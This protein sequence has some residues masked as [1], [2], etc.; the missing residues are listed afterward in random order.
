MN[1]IFELNN[2]KYAKLI[3]KC[4][5]LYAKNNDIS[6]TSAINDLKTDFKYI[7]QPMPIPIYIDSKNELN[8]KTKQIINTNDT[9][10]IEYENKIKKLND[11]IFGLNQIIDKLNEKFIETI[12][13]VPSER[14]IRR[15]E[16]VL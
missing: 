9:S 11:E 12:S 2:D 5:K 10:N 3:K 14:D 8:N 4:K 7:V 13:K 16:E 15:F 1:N 6:I